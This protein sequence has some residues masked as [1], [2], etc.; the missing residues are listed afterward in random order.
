MTTNCP[1]DLKLINDCYD[2]YSGQVN[3]RVVAYD[4]KNDTYLGKIDYVLFEE[5]IHVD[6]M[7]VELEFRR[8]GIA[9]KMLDRLKE[10]TKP[11]PINYGWTTREGMAFLKTYEVRKHG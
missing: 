3:C 4:K 11:S 9:T 8:C 1:I 2:A 6:M 7:E 10:E 5:Q